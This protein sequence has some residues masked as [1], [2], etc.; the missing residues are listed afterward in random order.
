M[1]KLVFVIYHEPPC[2]PSAIRMFV[3]DDDQLSRRQLFTQAL[4]RGLTGLFRGV[5]QARQELAEW[6]AGEAEPIY[7][8]SRRGMRALDEIE[9][10]WRREDPEMYAGLKKAQAELPNYDD[11]ADID[12]YIAKLKERAQE[13]WGADW[14]P[15]TQPP[16]D[17]E[18]P[19]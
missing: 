14:L 16:A 17:G 19:A 1:K 3:P 2:Y 6:A 8:W 15:G 18:T 4:P 10:R 12:R 7:G 5:L 11:P 9:E 13:R